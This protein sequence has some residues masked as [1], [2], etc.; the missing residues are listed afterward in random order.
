MR[1]KNRENIVLGGALLGLGVVGFVINYI[2]SRNVDNRVKD[3]K[4]HV[5]TNFLEFSKIYNNHIDFESD[6]TIFI[7]D[8]IDEVV[9][10]IGSCYEHI[11]ALEKKEEKLEEVVDEVI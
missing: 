10:E 8:Q 2:K 4:N 11:E 3:L 9:D 6:R 5:E 1:F 7:F